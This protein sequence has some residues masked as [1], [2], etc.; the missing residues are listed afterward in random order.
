ME[1]INEGVIPRRRASKT[2]LRCTDLDLRERIRKYDMNVEDG[3][4]LEEQAFRHYLVEKVAAARSEIRLDV[5]L[6][7]L[8]FDP[9]VKEP[10][11]KVG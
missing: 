11:E 4:E 5:L 6:R 3:E 2:M 1:R 10:R 8:R 9:F 7:G